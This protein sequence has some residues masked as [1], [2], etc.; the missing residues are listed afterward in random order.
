M[1]NRHQDPAE[2]NQ[3]RFSQAFE[4]LFGLLQGPRAQQWF[5]SLVQSLLAVGL[6]L[7][8]GAVLIVIIG[9][10]PLEAFGALLNGAVGS[11][12]ALLRTLRMASPLIFTGLAV[13]VAFRSGMINLGVEGALYL[14]A[15]AA[16]LTGIFLAGLPPLLHLIISA[17][18]GGLAGAVWT[19]IPGYLR[20]RFQVDEIVATLMLNYVAILLTDYLVHTFF[21]DPALGTTSDRPATIPIPESASLPFLSEQYGLT[22]SILIGVVIVGLLAWV[23]RYTVWGF[24]SEMVGLNRIFARFG[25]V[26]TQKVA[27]SSMVLSGFLGGLAGAME[28]LGIYGR[29]ISGFSTGL[30]FDGITVALMG[31]LSPIGTF[32]GALFIGGMKNGGTSMELAVNVPRDMVNVI[33][34]LI[35]IFITAQALILFRRSAKGQSES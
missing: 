30:G 12:P 6:A 17:L 19:F 26:Y 31:R 8:V 4:N 10:N 32:L 35:L 15:L 23:Y 21:L 22:I 20:S 1:K 25:G 2:V 7:G 28:S 14:G 11:K 13:A 29:Y 5:N 27:V 24:E 33:Q 18:V 3:D 34:G 9:E 16:A